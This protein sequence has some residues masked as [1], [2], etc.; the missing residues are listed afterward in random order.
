MLIL[1]I[2]TSCDET[3]LSLVEEGPRIVRLET[4][5]S[6]RFHKRF[7]GIIPELAQRKHL[8]YID[9]LYHRVFKDS[10]ASIND[11]DAIGVVSHPG[12]IGCLLV[13]LNFARALSFSWGK[14]LVELN[15]L[16]A[17]LYAAFFSRIKPRLPFLGLVVS[18]GHTSIYYV[19]DFDRFNLLGKTR[20][21]ACGEA[22]DKVAKIL[23]L[24]FPGGPLIDKISR[25]IR[26]SRFNFQCRHFEDCLDFSFSGI[27]TSVLYKVRELEEDGRLTFAIKKE[28]AWAFQ[29]SCID[30]LIRNLKRALRMHRVKDVVIGGGVAANSYFRK[31]LA[32][33]SKDEKIGVRVAPLSLCQDNAAM[34]AGLGLELY[35]KE[36]YLYV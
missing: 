1:G 7:G 24:G 19:E 32:N 29:K 3:S 11:V 20:D 17:H 21:D 14:P 31:A 22:F 35:K 9:I 12:L 30:S 8:Q 34:V 5:S 6:L 18:G 25:N 26:K 33:L 16:Y 10:G 23:N 36:I 2:E 15:H 4:L 13:G 27:K 28:I